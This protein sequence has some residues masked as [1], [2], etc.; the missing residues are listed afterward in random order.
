M[1]TANPALAALLL[2][3][4]VSSAYPVYA[5]K[6]ID[7]DK[8][9]Q[10]GYKQMSIGNVDEA[11]KLFESKVKAH[12]ES[13]ACHTALGRALKKKG[14]LAQAKAEFRRAIEAEPG[15]AD[16]YYELG[17]LE[18]SDKQFSAAAQAF[19]KY[20]SLKPDTDLK[21]VPDRIRYCKEQQ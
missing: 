3:L 9:L 10:N 17:S 2:V 18:E 8:R 15:Y 21:G 19:E 20:L 14:K 4:T 1:R 5:A 7:W 13:A 11:L 12:P 16:A 6:A